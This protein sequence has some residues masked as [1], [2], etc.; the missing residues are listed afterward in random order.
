MEPMRGRPSM[1][2]RRHG[3]KSSAGS[4]DIGSAKLDSRCSVAR[5]SSIEKGPGSRGGTSILSSIIS[6][7]SLA[8]W[9]K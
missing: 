5:T 6:A 4:M 2:N 1:Q 9:S 3:E 8:S 7:K